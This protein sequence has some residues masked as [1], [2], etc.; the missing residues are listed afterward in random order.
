MSVHSTTHYIFC[1]LENFRCF[2]WQRNIRNAAPWVNFSRQHP[3]ESGGWIWY[4]FMRNLNRFGQETMLLIL[5]FVV[6]GKN[7]LNKFPGI[8]SSAPLPEKCDLSQS[9]PIILTRMMVITFK[10]PPITHEAINF[11]FDVECF[12]SKFLAPAGMG[13]HLT[14]VNHAPFWSPENWSCVCRNVW[15]I[16]WAFESDVANRHLFGVNK[17]CSLYC[18]RGCLHMFAVTAP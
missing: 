9:F 3:L 16:M 18:G 15:C 10:Q 1:M 6:S 5:G 2:S 4:G 14:L 13:P 17:A 11:Q 12:Y 7:I 8:T